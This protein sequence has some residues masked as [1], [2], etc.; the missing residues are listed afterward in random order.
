MIFDKNSTL[1]RPRDAGDP[2]HKYCRCMKSAFWARKAKKEK[3]KDDVE[4]T[5]SIIDEL[6]KNL[7]KAERVLLLAQLE[8]M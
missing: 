2:Q 1:A 7:T 5:P 8:G 3:V 6:T 4:A